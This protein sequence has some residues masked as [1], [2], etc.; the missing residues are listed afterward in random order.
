MSRI[1]DRPKAVELGFSCIWQGVRSGWMSGRGWK[2]YGIGT[3]SAIDR[4]RAKDFRRKVA[5]V[6]KR[7]DKRG[8]KK[9]HRGKPELTT[10][11]HTHSTLPSY[12]SPH[13][14]PSSIL[15]P[16]SRFHKGIIQA[17]R[18][19]CLPQ[20]FRLFLVAH[21]TAHG[22]LHLTSRNARLTP[23]AYTVF[24]ARRHMWPACSS[25]PLVIA[26][27]SSQGGMLL[28]ILIFVFGRRTSQKRLRRLRRRHPRLHRR[29]HQSGCCGAVLE[30]VKETL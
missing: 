4:G 8:Q 19:A 17:F 13:K 30:W 7:K 20:A 22:Y 11:W 25:S 24:Q 1:R 18:T 9:I 23:P 16:L 3:D 10:I 12:A 26:A 6:V 21:Q 28:V 15:P 14:S 27:Q 29:L 2:H 5:T